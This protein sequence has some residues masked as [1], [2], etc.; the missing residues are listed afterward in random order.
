MCDILPYGSESLQTACRNGDVKFFRK[1]TLLEQKQFQRSEVKT[2]LLLIICKSYQTVSRSLEDY[3]A[4]I[5]LLFPEKIECDTSLFGKNPITSVCCNSMSFPLIRHLLVR[6]VNPN[7]YDGNGDLPLHVLCIFRNVNLNSSKCEE[8]I[9]LLIEYN[10]DYTARNKQ[11]KTPLDYLRDQHL[12]T[13]FERKFEE[14]STSSVKP[15]KK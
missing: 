8:L 4:I 15:A 7:S 11:N 6:G 10:A 13:Y 14:W 12:H 3:I 1:M 9:Q 5:D 2:A